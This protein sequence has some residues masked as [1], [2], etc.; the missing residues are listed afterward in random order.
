MRAILRFDFCLRLFE[1][2]NMISQI[3]LARFK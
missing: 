3:S 2:K 1:I